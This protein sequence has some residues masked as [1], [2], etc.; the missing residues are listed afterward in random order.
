MYDGVFCHVDS[1][2]VSWQVLFAK[3][4]RQAWLRDR[5]TN[6]P[7]DDI[8]T[9][10]T[11]ILYHVVPRLLNE[12]EKGG[13]IVPCFI[14]GDLWEGNFGTDRSSGAVFMFDSNGYYAHYEME[15]ALWRTKHHM[16]H[17]VDYCAEYHKLRKP[18]EP[19]EELED[20]LKLYGLKALLMYSASTYGH[21]TRTR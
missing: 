16:M 6:G 5:I 12:L 11:S 18:S 19:R 21:P 17:T 2:E 7:L 15:L 20:R 8:D 14:H 13:K 1:I 3:M 9:A 4:L 10:I